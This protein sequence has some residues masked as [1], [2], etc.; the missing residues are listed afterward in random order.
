MK[1]VYL[2]ELKKDGIAVADY[3]SENGVFY[4]FF[5]KHYY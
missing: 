5:R 2:Q 3:L 1:S 4:N